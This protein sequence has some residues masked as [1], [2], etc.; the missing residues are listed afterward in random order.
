MK[1]NKRYGFVRLP[2]SMAY[3]GRLDRSVKAPKRS[4]RIQGKIIND[5][6]TLFFFK[7]FNL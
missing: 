5:L 1:K 2:Q 6:M 3:T 7:L 4:R